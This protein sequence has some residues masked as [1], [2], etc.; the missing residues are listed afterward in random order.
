[1]KKDRFLIGILVGIGVLAVLA[2]VLFSLRQTKA[3]Y[4]AED[5]P[6]GVVQNYVL[7]LYK[8]DY[9]RAYGYLAEGQGKPDLASFRQ[10]F[11]VQRFD[12]SNYGL[13]VGEASITGDDASVSVTLLNAGNGPFNDVNR[14]V[15]NVVLKRQSGAWKIVNMPYPYWD[16]SWYQANV[17]PAVPVYTVTPEK[18]TPTP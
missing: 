8:L 10:T 4:V 11:T 1:M 9:P 3:S 14:N 6:A 12:L 5:N 17:V 13:Q 15:Q 18:A 7:A 16:Y 2:I